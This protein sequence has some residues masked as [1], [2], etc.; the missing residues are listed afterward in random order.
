MTLE[1]K[2]ITVWSKDGVPPATPMNAPQMPPALARHYVGNS[3]LRQQHSGDSGRSHSREET[4]RTQ[5]DGH[6]SAAHGESCAGEAGVV[7]KG[8]LLAVSDCRRDCGYWS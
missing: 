1:D 4:V 2:T 6:P 7:N 8:R 3:P 5:G